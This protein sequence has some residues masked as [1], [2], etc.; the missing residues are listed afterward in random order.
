MNKLPALPLVSCLLM[1]LPL[2]SQ[3]SGLVH[4]VGGDAGF[5]MQPS[6]LSAQKTRAEVV[7]ELDLARKDGSLTRSRMLLGAGMVL[8]VRSEG[9]TKSRAQVLAELD[10]A[11]K[12]GTMLPTGDR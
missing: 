8:P 4:E 1:T 3:A 2:A 12:T 5:V 6:H 11:Q 7:A 9:A 10:L